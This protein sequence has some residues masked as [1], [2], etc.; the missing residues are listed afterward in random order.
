MW[1]AEAN[2]SE[3]IGNLAGEINKIGASKGSWAADFQ[4]VCTQF[5]IIPSPYVTSRD[6]T[7]GTVVSV[8]N[9]VIDLANWRA[10]LVSINMSTILELHLHNVEIK[11]QHLTDFLLGIDSIPNFAA[12]KLEYSI[13]NEEQPS[14]ISEALNKLFSAGVEYVSLRG[15][16]LGNELL[17]PALSGLSMNVTIQSLNLSDNNLSQPFCADLTRALRMN[18]YV[19]AVSLSKNNLNEQSLIDML[20]VLFGADIAADDAQFLKKLNAAVNEKN[21]NI[22]AL[23]KKRKKGGE[24]ELPE[25]PNL[26]DRAAVVVEGKSVTINRTVRMF[27][28]SWNSGLNLESFLTVFDTIRSKVAAVPN[29]TSSGPLL[30]IMKGLVDDT[31]SRE[32][33]MKQSTDALGLIL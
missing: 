24:T 31:P 2:R 6:T 4:A 7:R 27:D 5:N 25:L 8:V 12:F 3:A 28:F 23:N 22:K 15:C 1:R 9:S 29:S 18:P 11:A 17:V 33:L 21:K 10:I 32:R 19:N 16:K 14:M 30:L 26:P 13:I 20:T